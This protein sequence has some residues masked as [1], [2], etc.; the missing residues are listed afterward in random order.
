[1]P[2]RL[3]RSGTDK[4]EKI[5]LVALAGNCAFGFISYYSQKS[6]FRI[7]EAELEARLEQARAAA[8]ATAAAAE[9]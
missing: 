9:A 8:S 1:M 2:P 7:S 6:Q 5:L 4:L 3:S